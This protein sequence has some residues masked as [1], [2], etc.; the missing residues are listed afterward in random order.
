MFIKLGE[1]A[2]PY[3]PQVPSANGVLLPQPG[4]AGQDLLVPMV[5]GGAAY[6]PQVVALGPSPMLMQQPGTQLG[7]PSGLVGQ[8]DPG[9]FG[10]LGQAKGSDAVAILQ[11]W[12]GTAVTGVWNAQTNAAFVARMGR[13]GL[14]GHHDFWE[15]VVGSRKMYM[16]RMVPRAAAG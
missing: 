5:P 7:P 15:E 6:A 12:L 16:R 11:R 4:M 9:V 14:S 2:G 10:G 13:I 3:A 1:S 8:A